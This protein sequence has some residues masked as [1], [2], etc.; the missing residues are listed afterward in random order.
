MNTQQR[1]IIRA[2]QHVRVMPYTH[3][4][5]FIRAM[6]WLRRHEPRKRLTPAQR[7]QLAKVAYRYRAQLAGSLSDDLVPTEKPK[8]ED[9]IKECPQLQVDLLDG[10]AKPVAMEEENR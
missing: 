10:S 9:Y 3:D 2:L 5:R 8:R 6:D 4:G 7:Y 1:D